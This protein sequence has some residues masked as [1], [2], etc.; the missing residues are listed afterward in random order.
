MLNLVI[1]SFNRIALK[2]KRCEDLEARLTST[3]DFENGK[4]LPIAKELSFVRD[5]VAIPCI[6]ELIDR[7]GEWFALEGLRRIDTDESWKTMLPITTSVHDAS[8]AAYAKKI[9]R[10]KPPD[11]RDPRIRNKIAVAVQ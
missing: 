8:T 7:H 5:P 6:S 9:L 3:N 2:N 4:I 11:V 1:L 10:E